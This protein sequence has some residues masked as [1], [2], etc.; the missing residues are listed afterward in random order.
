MMQAVGHGFARGFLAALEVER[1]MDAHPAC[2]LPQVPRESRARIHAHGLL[3]GRSNPWAARCHWQPVL[4]IVHPRRS[5]TGKRIKGKT[6]HVLVDTPG[7][8]GG[9]SGIDHRRRRSASRQVGLAITGEFVRSVSLARAVVRRQRLSWGTSRVNSPRPGRHH[10]PI[11]R[12]RSSRGA[13]RMNRFIRL[14][15]SPDGHLGRLFWSI[16]WLNRCQNRTGQAT[17]RLRNR[18]R[19]VPSI[20]RNRSLF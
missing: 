10:S 2:A 18:Q 1:M 11:S 17:G 12:P 14:I 9:I 5:I 6:R 19:D 13:D 3:H 15:K 8:P 16:A 7:L 4:R 20:R